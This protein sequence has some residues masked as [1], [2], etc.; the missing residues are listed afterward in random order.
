[1]KIPVSKAFI[2]G[3]VKQFNRRK[4]E[5]G[6]RRMRRGDYIFEPLE[7]VIMKFEEEK[8]VKIEE[9]DTRSFAG[10]SLRS[11]LLVLLKERVGLKY[12]EIIELPL[13]RSLK[14]SSL[15][16]LYKRVKDKMDGEK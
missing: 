1:M 8:G 7:E 12:N 3:A 4:E 15:G 16:Q 14:Y 11:E 9:I 10:K 6:T 5:M 13:F 2:K